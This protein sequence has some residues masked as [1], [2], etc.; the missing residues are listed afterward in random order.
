[1]IQYFLI[2]LKN[3]IVSQDG[4]SYKECPSQPNLSSSMF[5]PHTS[6]NTSCEAYTQPLR[7]AP[8]ETSPPH[9]LQ[10]GGG[11]GRRGGGDTFFMKQGTHFK[12]TGPNFFSWRVASGFHQLPTVYK[13]QC[14]SSSRKNRVALLDSSPKALLLDNLLTLNFCHCHYIRRSYCTTIVLNILHFRARIKGF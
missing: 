13:L 9:L 4:S 11:E 1:M 6:T 3:A 2:E 8:C 12:S 7:K 14:K 5:L 10:G